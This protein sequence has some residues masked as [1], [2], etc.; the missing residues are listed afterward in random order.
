MTSE[1]RENK[2]LVSFICFSFLMSNLKFLFFFFN[3]T[4]II[5]LKL[6]GTSDE[7]NTYRFTMQ[8]Y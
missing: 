2:N 6:Y 1:R 7:N 4:P 8:Q 5:R 3:Y